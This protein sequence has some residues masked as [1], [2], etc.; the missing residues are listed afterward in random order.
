MTR[1]IKD[2]S[3]K[4]FEIP[5]GFDVKT[6]Y[7]ANKSLVIEKK[8]DLLTA[9]RK[10][11]VTPEGIRIL[12]G[13]EESFHKAGDIIQCFYEE[14]VSESGAGKS[15]REERTFNIIMLYRSDG[16]SEAKI[17]LFEGIISGYFARYIEQEAEKILGIDDFAIEGEADYDKKKGRQKAN[18]PASIKCEKIE[19]GINV[20]RIK[21][22][23]HTSWITAGIVAILLS[24]LFGF[25]HTNGIYDPISGWTAFGITSGLFVAIMIYFQ[26]RFNK[27][28]MILKDG[29]VTVDVRN[30]FGHVKNI[31]SGSVSLLKEAIAFDVTKSQAESVSSFTSEDEMKKTFK[32]IIALENGEKIDLIRFLTCESAEFIADEINA[33]IARQKSTEA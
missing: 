22:P 17:S 19:G 30:R 13:K 8:G 16:G 15:T 27:R 7:G 31:Y 29:K 26:T 11:T 23:M 14:K 4:N 3:S 18:L 21:M 12:E 24:P 2:I 6:D 33:E 20:A 5:D 28:S 32:I 1:I 10:I 25:D 9:S